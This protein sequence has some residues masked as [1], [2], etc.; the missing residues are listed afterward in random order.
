M[1]NQS[2]RPGYGFQLAKGATS[3]TEAWDAGRDSSQNHFMLG[4]IIEWFYHDLA[5]I[6]LDPSA[7]AYKK[8][9][10]KP[11]TPGDLE[12]GQS[13][14]QL[15]LRQ[16]R[17]PLDPAQGKL[18]LEVE[19]PANTT[20]TVYVPARPGAQVTESGKPA[21][22]APGVKYLREEDGAAVYEIA[23]G[24]YSFTAVGR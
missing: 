18:T 24:R 6:G 19:I 3:L 15:H 13:Q 9:V 10:I 8:I 1:N 17:K 5:G 22:D 14:L 23:S 12:L 21:A 2:A 16:D 4:H 7:P 11:A 20:A